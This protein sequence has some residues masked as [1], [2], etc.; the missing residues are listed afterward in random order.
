MSI[1][2]TSGSTGMV[3]GWGCTPTEDPPPITIANNDH[4]NTKCW[5][6]TFIKGW[7]RT[8]LYAIIVLLMMLVFLNIALT[9]WIIGTM[10][11]SMKGIGP[12]KIVKDGIHLEGQ[13]WILDNLVASS[14]TSQIAQPITIRSHRNFTVLVS[15][16]GLSEQ[17]KLVIK[18][19]SV[20]CSGRMFEVRDAHGN[21]VF[22]ASKDEVRVHANTMTVNGVGGLS[23]R[24]A[25]QASLVNAPPGSDL[26]LESLT[27]RL[28]LQAPQS[29]LLESR[30][31]N[32]DII[33]HSD[34][35]LNSVVGAIRINSSNIIIG[36]LKE[37]SVVAD[38]SKNTWSKK[39]YQLCACAT[40]KLFLAASDALCETQDDKLCR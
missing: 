31:G 2:D 16:P 18:R 34:I 7:R 14:I 17:A 39:I 10:R 27:R 9:L 32:I 38:S 1:E 8:A 3:H 25:V 37:A 35:K 20:E 33:S 15:E 26:M 22:H 6:N 24:N 11:L 19:D 21:S 29:I 36:N 23:V 13:A 12:I 40:G 5:S 28:D 4:T 30:A